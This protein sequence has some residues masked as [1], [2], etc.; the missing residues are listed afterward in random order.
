MSTDLGQHGMISLRISRASHS[1]ESQWPFSDAVTQWAMATTSAMALRS[2]MTHL[3]PP[4][5]R[6]L[7]MLL[8][9]SKS[10]RDGKFLGLPL[11]QDNEADMS[12]E[13][14]A[15]WVSQLKSEGMPF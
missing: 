14:V 8:T 7:A 2:F 11:D 10:V 5:Q 9:E 15:D 4:A 6:A 13:R 12:E 3:L 1:P